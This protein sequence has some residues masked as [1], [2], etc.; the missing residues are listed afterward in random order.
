V[1]RTITVVFRTFTA[2]SALPYPHPEQAMAGLGAQMQLPLGTG[3]LPNWAKLR[4]LGGRRSPMPT[5]GC[6][7]RTKPRWTREALAPSTEQATGG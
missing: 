2:T 1:A 4:S 7:G 3:E 5:A 6:G